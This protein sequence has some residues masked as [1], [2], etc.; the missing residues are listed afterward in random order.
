MNCKKC[1]SQS[2]AINRDT[3]FFPKL[4]DVPEGGKSDYAKK[5]GI[6]HP[7][8]KELID[9]FQ[10]H[11][12]KKTFVLVH[13]DEYALTCDP[14]K[15]CIGT[16]YHDYAG[17][18]LMD[19]NSHIGVNVIGYNHPKIVEMQK[20]IAECGVVSFI[21]GG[22]DFPIVTDVLPDAIDLNEKLVELAKKSGF[23][24]INR[25]GGWSTGAEAVENCMK[26]A[27][28][29][30]KRKLFKKWGSEAENNWTMLEKK[31]GYP[32]FGI[33][34]E[35][36]FHG[37]TGY[38]LNMTNS[39]KTQYAYF[40]KIPGI[41]H[42]PYISTDVKGKFNINDLVDTDVSLDRL[43]KEGGLEKVLAQGKIPSELLAFICLEPIQGEGGYKVPK[44]SYI[45]QMVNFCQKH[46]IVYIDDEIQAGMGRT[47]KFF[48]LS[49]F[50]DKAQNVV[51]SMA[52][53]LHV[54]AVLIEEDMNYAESG[55]A[56]TTTGYGRLADIAVGYAK[57][58]AITENNG[59]LM[60]NAVKM[61]NYF[62]KEVKRVNNGKITRVDGL[63]LLL[64]TDFE[65][66]EI[67]NKAYLGLV[68]RGIIPLTVGTKGIRWIPPLDIKK[69]E[70]DCAVKAIGEVLKEL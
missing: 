38:A 57:I 29:W 8:N 50:V 20:K 58:D 67:R 21:G 27:Y 28:D 53:G 10:K 26:I 69:Q 1:E 39:K 55:R 46:D 32:L 49:N 61:G 18:R 68:E 16:T 6:Y 3:E 9:R 19:F 63:G 42:I 47:G 43:L 59:A 33:A 44:K 48:A 14:T 5:T 30:K 36:C 2:L 51:I 60:K 7:K 64:V 37:R 65:T 56:S 35:K 22:T 41:K 45:Q 12:I 11:D 40:P 13:N 15:P 62:K 70:I 52:K 23:T 4:I 17:N 34:A 24:K 66:P 25:V 54:S 31:L